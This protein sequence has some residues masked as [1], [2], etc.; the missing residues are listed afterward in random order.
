MVYRVL[1]KC[2][3]LLLLLLGQQ[4]F[5][6]SQFNLLSRRVLEVLQRYLD[7]Y[8]GSRSDLWTWRKTGRVGTGA[9]CSWEC[10]CPSFGPSRLLPLILQSSDLVPFS[11]KFPLA[12]LGCSALPWL[13]C[14]TSHRDKVLPGAQW[15]WPCLMCTTAKTE[16]YSLPLGPLG[17]SVLLLFLFC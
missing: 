4:H 13:A 16:W 2:K 5:S 12:C 14:P 9:I 6:I 11:T 3:Q 1:C 15:V 7:S 17:S 10:P 8:I